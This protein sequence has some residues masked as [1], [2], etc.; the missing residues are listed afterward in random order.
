MSNRQSQMNDPRECPA[1]TLLEAAHYLI[2]P[3]ATIRYWSVGRDGSA[4]LIRIPEP[5][6]S[7]TLLSFFNLVELHI[8]AAIRREHKVKMAS[9]RKALQYLGRKAQDPQA[10]RYPLIS[11][12]LETDGLDLFIERYG[13]LINISQEGQMTMREVIDAALQRIERDANGIPIKLYPFTQSS[14]DGAPSL[15]SIDPRISAGRPVIT[16]T[17]LSTQ[18]IAERYKAGESVNDLAQDYERDDAEIEEAIRCELQAV[19]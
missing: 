1:Y 9:I 5:Q 3:N 10:K 7:P 12:E 16:G 19:A 6:K 4:P 15:V 11:H 8:L 13:Q 18:I 14:T 17:G 2:V